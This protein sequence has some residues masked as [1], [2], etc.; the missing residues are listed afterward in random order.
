MA[1]AL[2]APSDNKKYKQKQSVD[3]KKSVYWEWAGSVMDGAKAYN[4]V[5][6]SWKTAGKRM[7]AG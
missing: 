4:M 5:L 7:L 6:V 3:T 1:V 2:L